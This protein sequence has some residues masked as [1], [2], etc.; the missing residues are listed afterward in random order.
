MTNF[1]RLVATMLINLLRNFSTLQKL[2]HEFIPGTPSCFANVTETKLYMEKT[3]LPIKDEL[4]QL[5][6]TLLANGAESM[7]QIVLKVDNE[8]GTVLQSEK[9]L[10]VSHLRI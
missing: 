5:F 10:R 2:R 3:V 1:D 6:P 4:Y 7:A 9:P 8:K